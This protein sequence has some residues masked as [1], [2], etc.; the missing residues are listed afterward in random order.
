MGGSSE[1]EGVECSRL[2]V[3]SW[4]VLVNKNEDVFMYST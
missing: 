4:Y 1:C 2:D 3:C